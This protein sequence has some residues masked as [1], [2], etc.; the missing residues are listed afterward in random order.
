VEIKEP[1]DEEDEQPLEPSP[2]CTVVSEYVRQE[3]VR[4]RRNVRDHSAVVS[5]QVLEKE[6]DGI[7]EDVDLADD[8]FAFVHR[9]PQ[10]WI[11]ARLQNGHE[12][13]Q[14]LVFQ[15]NKLQPA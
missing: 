12:P 5:V 8:V 2:Q 14:Y 11:L 1:D 6:A 9:M 4:R 3:I 13:F 15:L 10:P 7:G